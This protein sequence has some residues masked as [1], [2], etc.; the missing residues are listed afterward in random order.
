MVV[1]DNV[2]RA[3]TTKLKVTKTKTGPVKIKTKGKVC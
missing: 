3:S 1:V 2:R